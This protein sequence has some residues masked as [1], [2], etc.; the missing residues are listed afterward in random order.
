M[1]KIRTLTA[2]AALLLGAT[3]CTP[4]EIQF[5]IAYTNE[6]TD[7]TAA[8]DAVPA[9]EVH[10]YI[11][12]GGTFCAP[13]GTSE[14][15]LH[16]AAQSDYF[17]RLGQPDPGPQPAQPEQPAPPAPEPTSRCFILRWSTQCYVAGTPEYQQAEI[18]EG[19]YLA[20]IHQAD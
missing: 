19:A 2:A 11:T 18:D 1:N 6:H 16:A 17:Q 8:S 4:Q 15:A 20:E 5:W 13:D 7:E 10:C 12:M 14:A 9:A 3:G